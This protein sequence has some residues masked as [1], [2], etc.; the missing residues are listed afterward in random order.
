MTIPEVDSFSGG[1][2]SI[3]PD[4]PIQ[5]EN[6]AFAFQRVHHLLGDLWGT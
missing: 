1:D 6:E 5:K 4:E 2:H 3:A